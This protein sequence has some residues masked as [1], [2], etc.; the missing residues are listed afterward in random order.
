MSGMPDPTA[1]I[2]LPLAFD[3]VA[4]FV[5]GLAGADRSLAAGLGRLGAV[6][7]GVVNAVGGGVLRDV[8]TREEPVL[9]KPGQFYATA[10]AVAA[11]LY[12]ALREWVGLGPV[13]A[14]VAAAGVG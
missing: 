7:V 12:V 13:A 10:A 14:A 6:L 4:T 11:V 1:P 2:Q 9:F 8:L 3:V 5:A